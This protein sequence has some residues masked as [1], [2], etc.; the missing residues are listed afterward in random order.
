MVGR[1]GSFESMDLQA[2][3]VVILGDTAMHVTGGSL[4]FLCTAYDLVPQAPHA[5]IR[6][7]P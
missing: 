7:E 1:N 2:E 4:R 3:D 5:P 6:I